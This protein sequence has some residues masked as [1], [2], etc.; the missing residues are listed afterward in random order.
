MSSDNEP[1]LSEQIGS[2]ISPQLLL[3]LERAFPLAGAVPTLT[4]SERE[5]WIKVGERAVVDRLRR[6]L[7]DASQQKAL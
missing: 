3:L 1:Q 6:W 2:L 7:E 5:I 4:R